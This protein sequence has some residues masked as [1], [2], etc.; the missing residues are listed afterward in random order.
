MS[1]Y[2]SEYDRIRNEFEHSALPFQTQDNIK[3][4]KVERRKMGANINNS[5]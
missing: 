3:Q 5:I 2:H 4:R 1:N